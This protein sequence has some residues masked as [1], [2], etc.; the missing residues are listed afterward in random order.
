VEQGQQGK[1][2]ASSKVV[3][4][5]E[6]SILW[7]Q[8]M[9][10]V[11]GKPITGSTPQMKPKTPVK[12]S[13]KYISPQQ[14]IEQPPQPF[15]NKQGTVNLPVSQTRQEDPQAETSGNPRFL[16]HKNIGH[17]GLPPGGPVGQT[18][19]INHSGN[20]FGRFGTSHP[21]HK[22]TQN[23]GASRRNAKFYGE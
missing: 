18:K 14:Q 22:G 4:H 20:V 12:S 17:K 15:A 11:R 21:K 6:I 9:K 2:I 7:R 10:K 8:A 16:K 1:E 23:L 13:P 19:P 3:N 5:Q